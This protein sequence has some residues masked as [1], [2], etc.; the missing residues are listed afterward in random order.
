MS[1]DARNEALTWIIAI[2]TVVGT[3]CVAYPVVKDAL[4]S[5]GRGTSIG[6]GAFALLFA[7]S[8]L[9]ARHTS[10]QANTSI[11]DISKVVTIHDV[12]G[13]K[14]TV[15]RRQRERVNR[16]IASW[17]FTMVGIRSDGPIEN[18]RIN[19][20]ALG[21]HEHEVRMGALKIS[22]TWNELKRK[23]EIIETELS[24]DVINTFLKSKE[25]TTQDIS[26]SVGKIKVEVNLPH[27]RPCKIA[28]A[29]LSY[30]SLPS[31]ILAPPEVTNKQSKIT[32]ER[33]KPKQ[34]E[35]YLVEW[36]W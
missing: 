23:G 2:F 25:T 27:N 6:F 22:K 7:A 15:V 9:W 13:K 10:D 18:L 16:E 19:N 35:Q 12:G 17:T 32:F 8:L 24:Y 14:A 20:V 29:L 11:L 3:I 36:E 31:Q 1:R 30:N 21:A 26:Y 33:E 28:R 5:L 4:P 34:G